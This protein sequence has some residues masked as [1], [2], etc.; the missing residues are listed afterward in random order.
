MS[1]DDVLLELKSHP[2]TRR[3]P[4]IIVSADAAVQ[5]I[6][7]KRSASAVAS[8]TKPLDVTECLR[9]VDRAVYREVSAGPA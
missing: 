8:L 7:R 4:V 2:R 1:G 6:D 5:Q 3:I 9:T